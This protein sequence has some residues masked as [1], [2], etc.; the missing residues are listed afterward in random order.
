MTASLPVAEGFS[1]ASGLLMAGAAALLWRHHAMR[2]AW[3]LRWLALAQAL[4]AITNVFA[5]LLITTARFTGYS[6]AIGFITLTVGFGSLAA[7]VVGIRDYA[8]RPPQRPWGMFLL[9]WVAGQVATLAGTLLGGLR[10]AGDCIAGGFFLYAAIL[11][12]GAAR[13]EPRVG[14]ALLSLVLLAQPLALASLTLAGLD[15]QVTRYLAA[16]PYALIGLVLLS[17]SLVRLRSELVRELQARNEAEAAALATR[18]ALQRSHAVQQALLQ[19]APVPMAFTPVVGGKVPHS[20]WNRAWYRCFGHEPG[21]KEGLA[22]GDFD[23]YVDP[24]ERE[25]YMGKVLA[26]GHEGPFEVR[27]R[28][29]SG[30]E[31]LCVMEG[32]VIESDEGAFVVSTFIDI[33]DQRANELHLREFQAMVQS[34]EDGILFI[35]QG[36]ITAANAGAQ[37]MLAATAEQLVGASPVDW[38]PAQQADGRSSVEAASALIGATLAGQ[39][40]RFHWLHRRANGEVFTVQISLAAVEGTPG[41]LAAILRDVSEDLARAHALARSEARFKSIIAVSNTGAWEYHGDS[42][43]LWCSPEYF[44]MLG[45]EPGA[46]PMDG[47]ANLQQVWV[48]LMHPDD[49]SPSAKRFADYLQAGSPG[50]Y[51]SHFRMRH[52]DGHW[53]WVWSRGQTL[54]NADGSLSDVTVGTH[55]DITERE[56][57]ERRLAELN[58]SLESRVEARTWELTQALNDL[59]RTQQDLI[60]SEKLAALGGLVAGVA[61]ELNTPIGN[62]VTVASTLADAEVRM[63]ERLAS[64]LTRSA[65]Q[66][67]LDIVREAGGMLSRNL[68]RAVNLV[69]SFKQVAVDQNNH[70]RRDYELEEILS[71]V[72][73]VMAPSLRKAHVLLELELRDQL[74]MDGYPGALTQVLMILLSNVIAHAFEGRDGGRVRISAEM[75]G[76]GWARIV[77]ADDGIGIAAASLGRIFEPFYTTKL[78]KGGSGLGLHIAYNVVTGTLGGRISAESELGRGTRVILDLPQMAPHAS[79]AISKGA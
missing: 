68:T 21:S 64:G 59:N 52:A 46:Y 27:L 7:L 38:S 30:A 34:A 78:G 11:A 49:A 45:Y 39:P 15:P 35:E 75:S 62:A 69:T 37:R 54:R 33:T 67:F 60:Q 12:A 14:H 76:P 32:N 50:L 70:Q 58:Q 66:E 13:R 53:V 5:P 4:A 26:R 24:C 48:D 72:Q 6:S 71:E 18:N 74:K 17:T 55:I 8:L 31:R 51:E 25:R 29:A 10:V 41:R 1:I 28:H 2:P 47:R 57:A 36:R 44:T 3:G 16:V 23:F 73:I 20:Y 61:H 22:G 40:Q 19:Q 65:L 43:Y 56:E 42:H 9:L 79:S 77:V 63:R